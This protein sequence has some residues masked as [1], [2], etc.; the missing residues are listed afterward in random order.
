[1]SNLQTKT[2]TD[3]YEDKIFTISNILSILRVLTLP[4]FIYFSSHF[5]KAPNEIRF[6]YYSLITIAFAVLTDYLDGLFARILNQGSELGRYL[7]PICDKITASIALFFI[8]YYHNFPGWLLTIYFIR[9]FYT[10]YMGGFLYFKRGIQGRP[11]WWG[12]FGVGLI[13]I[14]VLWY[15]LLPII[16]KEFPMDHFLQNPEI[17]SYILVI[18][19]IGGMVAYTIRYWVIV[20]HPENFKPEMKYTKRGKEKF[21]IID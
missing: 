3:L 20:F 18:K 5:S 4:F 14:A 1:M 21:R 12:K 2:L 15:M 9:E 13:A 11:N 10:F 17:I 7:D 8:Y 16:T 6:L 19:L